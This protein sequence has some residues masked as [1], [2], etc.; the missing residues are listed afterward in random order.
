MLT[1]GL[2]VDNR[3]ELWYP[4]ADNNPHYARAFSHLAKSTIQKFLQLFFIKLQIYKYYGYTQQNNFK[5]TKK[6][7]Y[8]AIKHNFKL[9]NKSTL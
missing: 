8:S 5:Q 7:S 2:L 4:Q 3:H 6:S 1:S 9:N